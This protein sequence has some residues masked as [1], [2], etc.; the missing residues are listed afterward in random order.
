MSISSFT[1]EILRYLP[2]KY[3]TI[4]L[5]IKSMESDIQKNEIDKELIADLYKF[6]IL[7][8]LKNEERMSD[9]LDKSKDLSKDLLEKRNKIIELDK[10]IDRNFGGWDSSFSESDSEE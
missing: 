3:V 1:I 4:F 7:N 6:N 9:F 10:E 5:L 8:L 2:S